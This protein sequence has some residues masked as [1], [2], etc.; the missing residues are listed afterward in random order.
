[1]ASQ[2]V[3]AWAVR[4]PPSVHGDGDYGFVPRLISIAREKGLSAYPG[5]GPNRWSAVHRLDAAHLYRLVLEKGSAGATYHH[6]ADE[7]MPFRDIAEVIGR[8][9]NFPVVSKSQQEA[10][11][12]FGRLAHFVGIDCPASSAQTQEWL[13][14]RPTEPGLI[15]DLD[16]PHYFTTERAA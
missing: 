8:H 3:H 9:L 13:G 2:G 5:D 16:H 12:H 4:L 7:G 6:V 14:W 10:A 1:M 11:D 15:P